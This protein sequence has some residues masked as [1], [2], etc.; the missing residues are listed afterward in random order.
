MGGRSAGPSPVGGEEAGMRSRAALVVLV[1]AVA[2]GVAAYG[3]STTKTVTTAA[4]TNAVSSSSATASSRAATT[5]TAT[6]ETA[7]STTAAGPPLCTAPVLTGVFL[8][9]QGAA[10]HGLLG[11]ALRNAS[12]RPCHTFGYPGVRFLSAAGSPLAT[13]STR[14]THDLLG[15]VPRIALTLGPGEQA[16]FRLVVTHGIVSRTG[17]TT[18]HALAVIPPDDTRT[19]RIA[20]ADGAY[21]CGTA[22]VTPLRPGTSAYP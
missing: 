8:G 15:A 14:T 18:A 9:Q 4:Q 5:S 13:V 6:T 17:C 11:F 10:G 2:L 20:I 3:S 7:T 12:G 1:I 21:E 22:T 19:L 16:S